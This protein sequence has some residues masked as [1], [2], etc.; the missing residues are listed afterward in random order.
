MLNYFARFFCSLT[1]WWIRKSC[2]CFIFNALANVSVLEF[3]GPYQENEKTSPA[4]KAFMFFAFIHFSAL[5]IFPHPR[6]PILSRMMVKPEQWTSRFRRAPSRRQKLKTRLLMNLLGLFLPAFRE[7]FPWFCRAWKILLHTSICVHNTI[8]QK[9]CPWP[10]DIG[11]QTWSWNCKNLSSL[12][13]SSLTKPGGS[14]ADLRHKRKG[15][16]L[17]QSFPFYFYTIA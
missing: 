11:N 14:V 15:H 9:L 5:G 10:E 7:R 12:S 6:V 8:V 4:L 1:I 16:D 17:S 3:A 13:L 2:A